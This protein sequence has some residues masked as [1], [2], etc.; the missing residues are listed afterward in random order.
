ML[1]EHAQRADEAEAILL[2]RWF[3]I[4]EADARVILEASG[5]LSDA[6]LLQRPY[7]LTG[8]VSALNLVRS[9]SG[10]VGGDRAT[11]LERYSDVVE[12]ASSQGA[13]HEDQARWLVPR[14]IAARWKGDMPRALA[15]TQQLGKSAPTTDCARHCS[16]TPKT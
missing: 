5:A 2:E 7:L 16:L 8:A 14:M 9:T 13:S 4:D 1:Q 15:L 12:I 10:E 3:G 6:E 11:L